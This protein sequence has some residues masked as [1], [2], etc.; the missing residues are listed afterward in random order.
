MLPI[1]KHLKNKPQSSMNRKKVGIIGGAG[2]TAG[3]LLF[4]KIIE[5]F[6]HKYGSEQD[7]EFPYMLLLNFPFSDMLSENKCDSLIKKE[8]NECFQTFER[9]DIDIIAIA[10]NTLHA[11]LPPLPAHIQFVHM[12]EETQKFIENQAPPLVLCTTTSARKKLHQNYFPCIYPD[13]NFQKILDKMIA[14]ITLGSDL[15]SIS[16][17]LSQQLPDYPILLGCTEFS[18]LNSQAPLN[19]SILYD[20]NAIVAEKI[21]DLCFFPKAQP[22]V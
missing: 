12:I 2:P 4:N 18:Y 6:Q 21:A 5:V 9:N 14:D 19:S 7:F 1:S 11:F 8:L 22:A 17:Q 10:C 3:S 15:R 20:P 16:E 13:L